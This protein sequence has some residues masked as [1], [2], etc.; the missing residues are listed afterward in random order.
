M[1]KM[2]FNDVMSVTM[3]ATNTKVLKIN[4]PQITID[5]NIV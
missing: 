5:I 4:F 2:L 3:K 1:L